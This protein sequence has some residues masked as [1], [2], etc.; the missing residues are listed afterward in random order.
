MVINNHN[1]GNSYDDERN[2]VIAIGETDLLW[3]ISAGVKL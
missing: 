3:S 2:Y 1:G